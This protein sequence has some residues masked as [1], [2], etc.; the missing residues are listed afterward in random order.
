M[1]QSTDWHIQAN[2]RLSMRTYSRL[3]TS[4]ST[5]SMT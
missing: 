5:I 1:I 4:S 2:S 3:I